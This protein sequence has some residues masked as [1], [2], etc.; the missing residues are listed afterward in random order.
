MRFSDKKNKEKGAIA[1]ILTVLILGVTLLI[2]MGL[3][4]IF[5]QEIKNSGLVGQSSPAFYA[6][7]AGAEYAL[8]EILKADPELDDPINCPAAGNCSKT[9]NFSYGARANVS[10]TNSSINSLGFFGGTRR[11]VQISW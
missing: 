11:R 10:W 9:I 1:I 2:A 6:A 3:S 5:V 8:Y 4:L 7:D